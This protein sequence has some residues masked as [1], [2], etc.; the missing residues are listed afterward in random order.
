M[1][2]AKWSLSHRYIMQLYKAYVFACMRTHVA[3][4]YQHVSC[5]FDNLCIQTYPRTYAGI[6]MANCACVLSCDIICD[7]HW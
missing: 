2:L 5:A 1:H 4:V 3:Q 7:C 6:V